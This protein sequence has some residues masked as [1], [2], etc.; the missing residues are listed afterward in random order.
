MHAIFTSLVYSLFV[1]SLFVLTVK[2]GKHAKTKHA[3]E[4]K[5]MKALKDRPPNIIL[6]LG[7]V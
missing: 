3:Q 7:M 1:F 2:A 5:P 6:I 4:V